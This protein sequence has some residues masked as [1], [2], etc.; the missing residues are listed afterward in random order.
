LRCFTAKELLDCAKP[1]KKKTLG[2]FEESHL[3]V[4]LNDRLTLYYDMHD[5][6]EILPEHR[7]NV[8]FYFKRSFADD[9][10]SHY[11]EKDKI[12]PFGFNYPVFRDSFDRFSIERSKLYEG[13]TRLKS[14]VR[15]IGLTTFAGKHPQDVAN[16]EDLPKFDAEPNVIFMTRAWN[17]D[18]IENKTKREET[19]QINLERARCV[20]L[21]RK[22]FGTKFF[23]GLAIDDYS[24]KNFKEFLLPNESISNQK[25]YL[26]TLKK[27][28]IAVTTKGLCNSNGWK[29]AEYI[30]L[31]K[32][33]VSEKLHYQPGG[34]FAEN[35]NYLRFNSPDECVEKAVN[36]FEDKNL[37]SELMQ[38]NFDYYQNF[39]R[40]DKIILN[41]LRVAE[42]H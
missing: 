21:L 31:S 26:K 5:C 8:D 23:G 36:L 20:G 6:G 22:E 15:G 12:F 41:T 28:P 24:Q 33:V 32:A 4:I 30:A 1:L 37:R 25:A 35:R 14:F 16:F 38:N 7:E 39:L 11:P 18:K 10:V 29:L 40:P 9:I 19:E 3:R 27:S 2:R 34:D 42:N 13:K 17:P